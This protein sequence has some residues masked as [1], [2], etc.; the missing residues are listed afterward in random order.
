MKHVTRIDAHTLQIDNDQGLPMTLFARED[1]PVEPKAIAEV[2]KLGG[3]CDTVE[4]LKTAGFLEGHSKVE[5]VVLTPDFHRGD[6]RG[7]P[8]GTCLATRGFIVPKAVGSDICCGMRFVMTDVSEEE[9]VGIGA[10][11]DKRL[12]HLFFEGGRDIAMTPQQREALFLKG[13]PGLYDAGG[14]PDGHDSQDLSRIHNGGSIDTQGIDPCLSDFITGSGGASRD[15][16]IGSI[17]GGNH[18]VE[19]QAVDEIVERQTAYQWGLRKGFVAIMA[20]SG[21]VSIGARIGQAAAE[22][23]RLHWPA[24]VAHPDNGFYMLPTDGDVGCHGRQYLSAMGNGANFAFANRL[25]LTAMAA[26][27]LSECL[28]RTIG[29]T[30]VYDAPHNLVWPQQDGSWLHRKGA[31]PAEAHISDPEFPDGHPVIVPGSM[32]TSS[33]LLRGRGNVASLCSAAHGAGRLQP[34]GVARHR[35][36]NELANLRIVTTVERRSLRSD[37]AQGVESALMEEAPGCYKDP[38]P[39]VATLEGAGISA[40]VA[41]MRPILTVKG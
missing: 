24:G 19:L 33:W 1:V 16:Q 20:H 29:L 17:G 38:G 6:G 30:L 8:I 40:A 36:P 3:M 32:G 28:G 18:F 41:R 37:I 27:A 23:S 21:S 7:I 22:K 13:L 10:A 5:R 2:R 35:N 12:R 11:L 39:V 4:A 34:R 25:Y 26:R 9:L 31:C 14:G 15:D